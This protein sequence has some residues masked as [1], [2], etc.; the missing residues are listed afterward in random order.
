MA[1]NDA[2]NAR[3]SVL[4]R[5][6]RKRVGMTQR[7]LAELSTISIRAIRDLE[8]ECTKAPRAQTISL[9]A[10]ALRLSKARRAELEAA[11]GLAAGHL[12][13]EE[14]AAP[15]ALLGPLIGRDHETASLEN[16]L[17]HSGHRLIKVVGM[18]GIGKTSLIQQV[19]TTLHHSGRLSVVHLERAT[20]VAIDRRFEAVGLVARI[21]QR[22][23][24]EPLL[25]EVV[26]VLA[27]RDMLLIVDGRDLG[28]DSEL[29]LRLLLH[30]CP[31]L[32]VLYETC[33]SASV[34]SDPT[35]SVFPLS[36]PD[37]CRGV[38]SETDFAAYSAVRFMLSRC[39]HLYPASV[40]DPTVISAIAGICWFLDGIPA[41]LESAA[42]WLLVYEPTQLLDTAARSPLMLTTSSAKA[43]SSLAAWLKRT[44][45]SLSAEDADALRRLADAD[46]WTVE[47]AVGHLHG[48]QAD[49]LRFIHR[50]R[51]CGLVRRVDAASGERPRF[52]VLNLVRHLLMPEITPLRSQERTLRPSAA[53]VASGETSE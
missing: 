19:A 39:A 2:S 15:P 45:E 53:H 16:L 9:L 23:G 28:E 36:V 20:R 34:G 5:N 48:S 10:D 43:N 42:S 6:A 8:L 33:E 3:F 27:G 46:D 52:T 29:E 12:L 41:A 31:G 25:D 18:P 40:S 32:R 26:G 7:Q 14:L 51:A 24:C 13:V 35:F 22:I 17:V 38:A 47:E 50:L 37:W 4:L 1:V 30:R 11:A 44:V 49:A 21:A